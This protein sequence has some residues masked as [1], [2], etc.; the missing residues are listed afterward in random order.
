MAQRPPRWTNF[1]IVVLVILT[2][3]L[4]LSVV[5]PGSSPSVRINSSSD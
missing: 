4:A 3:L 5:A 1:I 2:A